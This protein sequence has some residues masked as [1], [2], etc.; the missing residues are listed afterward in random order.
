MTDRRN[1]NEDLAKQAV[2]AARMKNMREV[3]NITRMLAGNRRVVE[4]P[5]KNKEGHLLTYTK[6]QLER[7]KEH[8]QELLNRP[9]PSEWPDIPAMEAPLDI[10]TSRP[11]QQSRNEKSNKAPQEWKSSRSSWCPPESVKSDLQPSVEM[12]YNLFRKIWETDSVPSE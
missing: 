4:Q 9:V 6:A 12:L 11:M 7:W 5:V 1:F 3:Y 10:N 2:V 8:F